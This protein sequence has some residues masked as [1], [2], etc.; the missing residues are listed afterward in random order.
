MNQP[1]LFKGG[2]WSAIAK[3]RGELERD[4]GWEFRECDRLLDNVGN[5]DRMQKCR[6]QY[7]SD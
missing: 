3:K 2:E 7:E 4:R 5:N 1:Y 6:F